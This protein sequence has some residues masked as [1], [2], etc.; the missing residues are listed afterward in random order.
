MQSEAD[1]VGEGAT[2]GDYM[3]TVETDTQV[4]RI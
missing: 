4:T 2:A 3:E 1:N